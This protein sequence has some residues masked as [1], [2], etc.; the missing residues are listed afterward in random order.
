MYFSFKRIF[1][2]PL[3]A[4]LIA[5]FFFACKKNVSSYKNK[6][7]KNKTLDSLVYTA[8]KL[9]SSNSNLANIYLNQVLNKVSKENTSTYIAKYHLIKGRIYYYEDNY[10]PSVQHLDTAIQKFKKLKMEND[11]AKAYSFYTATS[12]LMGNYPLAIENSFR[13][14]SLNQKNNNINALIGNYNYLANIYL[15]QND[16]VEALKFVNKADS[17]LCEDS[18][19]LLHGNILS[20][21]AKIYSEGNDYELASKYL[22]RAY[23]VRLKC[24]NIRHIASSLIQLANF[25]I[26]QYIRP[27]A[28]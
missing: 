2:Y 7:A 18:I 22:K 26:I 16:Y 4:I 24:A 23:Q 9:A 14:I 15:Q 19:S 20:T 5:F 11:L 6:S 12:A 3:P 21:K 28:K 27:E 10:F 17:L 13:A 1:I 8:E 25:E